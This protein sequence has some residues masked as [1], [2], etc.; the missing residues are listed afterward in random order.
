MYTTAYTL[1]MT[2]YSIAEA[3]KNLPAVV[4]EALAGGEVRLTRHG[5]EVA[6]LVSTAEY[7]R[8][9]R[10]KRG[11]REAYAEWQAGLSKEPYTEEDGPEIGPEFWD[12][13]RDRSATAKSPPLRTSTD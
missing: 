7:E 6:V 12:A 11:F 4:D 13:L 5:R 2:Q 3:R 9:K 8:L 1:G 10:G